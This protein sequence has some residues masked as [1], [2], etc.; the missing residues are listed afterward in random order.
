MKNGPC[1]WHHINSRT[2]YG[3]SNTSSIQARFGSESFQNK[4]SIVPHFHSI[5]EAVELWYTVSGDCVILENQVG[6]T[7]VF[8]NWFKGTALWSR[9]MRPRQWMNAPSSHSAK[10]VQF[11]G[12]AFWSVLPHQKYF[13]LKPILC[14]V[15]NFTCPLIYKFFSFVCYFYKTCCKATQRA[16]FYNHLKYNTSY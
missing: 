11:F 10:G 5:V 7:G 9:L 3:W 14:Q 1:S 4:C 16:K 13:R 8:L 6:L 2:F 12:S 15:F